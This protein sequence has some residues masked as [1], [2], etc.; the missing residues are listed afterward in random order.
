[1][2][3]SPGA[4]GPACRLRRRYAHA[5]AGALLTGLRV[6]EWSPL[7]LRPYAIFLRWRPTAAD[8]GSAT[9][10]RQ[11]QGERRKSDGLAQEGPCLAFA[12]NDLSN[13]YGRVL[14]VS[15]NWQYI[16]RQLA[17]DRI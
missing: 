9:H 17:G 16:Y 2:Y 1:M 13:I 11:G 6:C 14:E 15:A 4:L 12:Y 5:P 8:A 10:G 7:T 3:P